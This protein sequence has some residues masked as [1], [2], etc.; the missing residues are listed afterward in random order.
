MSQKMEPKD[1]CP[2]SSLPDNALLKLKT[3]LLLFGNIGKSKWY[4]GIQS[5]LY[6]KP[7]KLGKSSRWVVGEI[8]ATLD[9]LK[10]QSR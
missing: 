9:A 4:A 10:K 7:V 6:P 5:G 3:V 2:I 1:A 8:R